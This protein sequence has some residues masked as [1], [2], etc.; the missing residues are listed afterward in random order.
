ML[1]GFVVVADVHY[2]ADLYHDGAVLPA[3]CRPDIRHE[4]YGRRRW[5][6][7]SYGFDGRFHQLQLCYR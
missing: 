2:N 5:G 3:G 6:A 4:L 1:T 7:F